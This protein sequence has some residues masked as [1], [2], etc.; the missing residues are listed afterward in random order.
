MMQ[1]IQHFFSGFILLQIP[2]PLTVGFKNMFQKGVMDMPDLAASYVS[3]VSWYFLVMYGLRG[4]LKL[5][6]GTPIL[7]QKEQDTYAESIGYQYPPPPNKTQ[8]ADSI[9]KMLR[10]E[11][12]NI[13]LLQHSQYNFISD[14]DSIERRLLGKARYPQQKKKVTTD[15]E[16]DYANVAAQFLLG[17]TSS[18]SKK[19]Q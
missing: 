8:D 11:A 14:F 18:S 3:S 2:F 16:D 13:E 10:T 17:T 6:I 12:D 19:K 15:D 5:L 7:E 4:F 1:G 9:A